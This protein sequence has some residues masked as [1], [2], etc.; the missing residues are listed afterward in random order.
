MIE[1]KCYEC[2]KVLG[3]SDKNFKTLCNECFNKIVSV[4][5]PDSLIKLTS[6]IGYEDDE[7][8]L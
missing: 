1:I 6:Y 4:G 8:S 5:M 2:G 3:K 7:P